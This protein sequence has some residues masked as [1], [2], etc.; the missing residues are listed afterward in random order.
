MGVGGGGGGGMGRGAMVVRN[1]F[2]APLHGGI[3][4]LGRER[5]GLVACLRF[6]R[7]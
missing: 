5:S 7:F 2:T 4:T 3:L 1:C 6:R